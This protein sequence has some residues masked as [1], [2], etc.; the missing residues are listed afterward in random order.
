MKYLIV[1]LFS[2][3]L[4][5]LELATFA[6]GCFWCME[7]PF[8]DLKG[9]KSV[10]SGF[11]GGQIKNPSYKLVSSGETKHIEV[12]QVSYD[13]KI[14]SYN[15]LL[16]VFWTN[17]DPTDKGGQFV[18]RGYQYSTAIFYHNKQQKELAL[19]SKEY[20]QN[21]KIEDKDIVT[22]IRSYQAFY[23]AEE[24]HQDFY[25]KSIVTK[26]KYKYYRN[27]S[28]R[29]KFL[30]RFWKNVKIDFNKKVVIRP[31]MEDLKKKLTPLQY[32][33]TQEDGT[34]PPFK[35]EYWDNKAEGIYVDIVSKEALF[36]STHKFKSGTGWPSFYETIEKEN[37]VEKSDRKLFIKRT[38]VRSKDGNSHLGHVFN[39]GPK[40]TGLRYCIN[41]ASLEFIPKEEL[42]AKGYE[43][44][45]SLFEK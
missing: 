15:T 37:I 6:G 16:K 18:D 25:K 8:E 36:S 1:S 4:Y 44:Y 22:P 24:Y 12:V 32:K 45:L 14:V 13:P 27:A 38:E 2:F 39:D 33:V 21:L 5:A 9:V 43:K 11:S 10:I 7:K 34:E 41:S 35:N 3:S 20:I 19:K 23:P 17:I 28:G 30:D 26:L 31:S 42:K 29:D 40:P